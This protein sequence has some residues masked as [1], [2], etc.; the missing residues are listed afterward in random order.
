M[1]SR[2]GHDALAHE[3]NQLYWESERSVNQIAEEMELSKG[4]LYGMIRPL[5]AGGTCPRCTG[6]M[7]YAN[8]TARERGLVSCP[9]C[10][11]EREE[12]VRA[13]ARP[14]V[15]PSVS[16]LELPPPSAPRRRLS[17]ALPPRRR[18]RDPVRLGVGLLLIATGLWIFRGLNRR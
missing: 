4:M 3:A 12:A 7:E 10:G 6:A 1:E 5:P 2:H 14:P 13:P 9:A 18:S 16:D 17:D 15:L 11:H 8:R